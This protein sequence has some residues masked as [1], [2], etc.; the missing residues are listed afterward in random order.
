MIVQVVG[1]ACELCDHALRQL[2]QVISAHD[3]DRVVEQ[4]TDF[5]EIIALKVYAVPGIIVNGIL[6]SVG[7]IPDED[8]L[9]RWLRD[10]HA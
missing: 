5:D 4:I 1:P 9:I 7:R 3:L 2:E 6:K 8:E 10:D